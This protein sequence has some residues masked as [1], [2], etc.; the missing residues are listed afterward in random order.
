MQLLKY[1]LL[2]AHKRLSKYAPFRAGRLCTF[3]VQNKLRSDTCK[4]AVEVAVIL[5]NIAADLES[6]STVNLADGF[7]LLR[8]RIFFLGQVSVDW[9]GYLLNCKTPLFR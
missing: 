5:G 3:Y 8:S 6:C 4:L 7:F 9:F 2:T 1:P